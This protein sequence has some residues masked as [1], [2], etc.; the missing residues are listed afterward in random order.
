MQSMI[1]SDIIM[2]FFSLLFFFAY[3]MLLFQVLTDIF[4]DDDL[5]IAFKVI[6]VVLLLV[7]PVV[8]SIIYL[9]IRGK[10]MA[11][12]R[13][14]IFRKYNF[15]EC[16]CVEKTISEQ[17]I[18]ASELRVKGV[19]NEREYTQIKEKILLR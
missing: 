14:R 10:G 3:L 18:E 1:F 4:R 19:I 5:H 7:I 6:W 11:L 15:P 13:R 16:C 2:S 12:R 8:C 17:I 9:L